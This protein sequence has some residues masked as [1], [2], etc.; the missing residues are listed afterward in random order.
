MYKSDTQPILIYMTLAMEDNLAKL[1]LILS[2]IEFWRYITFGLL[3]CS[4]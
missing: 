2:L 3:Q 1:F 4:I